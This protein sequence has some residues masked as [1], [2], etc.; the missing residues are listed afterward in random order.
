MAWNIGSVTKTFVAVV[1]LQ[2]AQEG[3]IDLDAGIEG[4]LPDLPGADRI[5]PRQLLQ[6]TS[7]LAEYNDKPAVLNDAQRTWT[8]SELIAVAE[9]AGRV[10]EPGGRVPLRE[11]ELH[12]ARRDHPS[13]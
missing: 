7:G 4:Y 8:P 5:T 6:H 13:R 10:G 11:H 3:R 2:L 9:A 1:V 12:R